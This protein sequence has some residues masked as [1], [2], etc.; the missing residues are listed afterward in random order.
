M[1]PEYNIYVH[2]PFCSSKCNYCAF[3]SHACAN[4]DWDQYADG[5]ISEINYWGKKLCAPDV[6]TVFFGGGTPSLMPPQFFD[7]ILTAI[8]KNFNLDQ[9]C[10]VTLESNPGTI[11]HDRLVDF[12]NAGVT[13]LSVGVQS[14]SDEKLKFLGRRHTVKDAM[15]LI[16]D[17]I[18]QNIRLSADFIYGMPHDTTDDIIKMCQD[19]NSIGLR[20]CSLYE[21]TLEPNT[22]FGKM[23]LDMPSNTE[24]ADMYMAIDDTLD[25]QRYE[26][27]NYAAPGF[28]C[29]HNQ[30]VWDG[31]PY[32]GIGRGAAGRIK[33]G[34]QW[35]EQ[36]GNNEVFAKIDSKTR[37]IERIITGMRQVRG[38]KL[39]P[40]IQKVINMDF[41][42]SNPELL[43]ITTDNRIAATKQGM[44]ILDDIIL[45]MTR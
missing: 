4:P 2:V 44:L 8:R 38:V 5:I 26:V 43:N 6:A 34:N 3:F 20:H 36:M 27:S 42:T 10:E 9:N 39:D 21:L 23:N 16:S 35:Y 13:R 15:N 19:I 40:G 1:I 45:N 12:C 37:A 25:L 14:L 41:V 30:N 7:K 32:I 22:V 28:E 18:K 33:I 24:M 31:A 29:A 17:A 11:N